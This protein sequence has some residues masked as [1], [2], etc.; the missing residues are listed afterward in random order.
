[1]YILPSVKTAILPFYQQY[2][3]WTGTATYRSCLHTTK[4]FPLL[5]W[6]ACSQP[7]GEHATLYHTTSQHTTPHSYQYTPHNT[8][9]TKDN[10]S[11]PKP[12]NNDRCETIS[13][14]DRWQ[15]STPHGTQHM[16]TY[17]CIPFTSNLATFAPHVY[18]TRMEQVE[19][20]TTLDV[21][22]L[23]AENDI[24]QGT[25]SRTWWRRTWISWEEQ[26][27]FTALN[28]P[29]FLI[30]MSGYNALQLTVY[31]NFLMF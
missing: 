11:T 30:N 5:A 18:P 25:H 20:I 27:V 24:N 3:Q 17:I 1:M 23:R 7:A 29:W 4:Q 26:L 31:L 13:L 10:H 28:S 12:I 21:E 16:K 14:R 8:S 9:N 2:I 22:L 15:A 6:L 19:L